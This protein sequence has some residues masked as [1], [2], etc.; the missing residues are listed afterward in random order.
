MN[1]IFI[2]FA[3][4][5]G[6]HLA[7]LFYKFVE[8]VLFTRLHTAEWYATLCKKQPVRDVPHIKSTIKKD[9]DYKETRI[10]FQVR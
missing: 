10:G 6:W 7:K 5:I 2:G 4:S 3:V 9:V 8:E 1:Y